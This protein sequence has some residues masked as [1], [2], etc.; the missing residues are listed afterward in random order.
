MRYFPGSFQWSK[1]FSP[2]RKD[3]LEKVSIVDGSDT[4]ET[5]EQKP[6]APSSRLLAAARGACRGRPPVWIMRQAGRYLPAYQEVRRDHSFVEMCR[7][8]DLAVEVS[9]Q[10]WREF[11]MDAVIVF[12][13]ILFVPEAMG[14]PLEFTERGPVFHS[15]VRERSDVRAL[16]DPERGAASGPITESLRRLR[17]MLP[18]EVAVLGFAGAPFTLAA[19]LVEGDFRR[20]GDRIRRLLHSDP[21]MVEE[22]LD[23]ITEATVT[24]VLEQVD[25]GADAI[26]LFDTWAGLLALP[27]YERFAARYQAPIFRAL[28]ERDVPSILYVKDGAHLVEC[29]PASGAR[30]V[31]LDWRVPLDRARSTL[32]P[33]VGL[34]GNLDPAALFASPSDVRARTESLLAMLPEDPAY[35]ANLGHGI[36]PET[37]VESVRAFVDAVR[38][39]ET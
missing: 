39:S 5:G 23:R 18:L 19:Y 16:R 22:L 11:G 28:A 34:Q 3:R 30:V 20:S 21:S 15:S 24:Y 36:L 37:P 35:I 4:K 9:L 7:A 38:D 27:E 10:P 1:R 17:R 29:L 13:D 6:N 2:S 12:Y 32:G 26:Q 14:A 8:P 31:S 25:A 33:A